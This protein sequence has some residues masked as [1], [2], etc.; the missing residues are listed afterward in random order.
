M[1]RQQQ[2]HRDLGVGLAAADATT[3]AT[4]RRTAEALLRRLMD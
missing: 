4:A 3:M 2:R 1:V